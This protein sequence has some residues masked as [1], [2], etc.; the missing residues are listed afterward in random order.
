M[1]NITFVLF[2]IFCFSVLQTSAQKCGEKT[3]ETIAEGSEIQEINFGAIKSIKGKVLLPD[4]TVAENVVVELFRNILTVPPEKANY[5]Q[6]NE[7][8][9][10][11]RLSARYIVT[12]GKFCFKNIKAGNY[13]LRINSPK[14][15]QSKISGFSTIHLFVTVDPKNKNNKNQKLEVRLAL[16]I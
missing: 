8:L 6:I 14:T 7:I 13:L 3:N 1:R 9:K 2:F 12:S 5:I 4:G 16:G 10:E 11:K 15:E